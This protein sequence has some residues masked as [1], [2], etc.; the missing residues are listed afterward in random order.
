MSPNV[1]DPKLS[2]TYCFFD[3]GILIFTITLS[4]YANLKILTQLFIN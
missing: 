2:F 1:L 3:L 4:R